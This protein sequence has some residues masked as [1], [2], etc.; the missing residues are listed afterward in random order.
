MINYCQYYFLLCRT[1]LTPLMKMDMNGQNGKGEISYELAKK[2][3]EKV[4]TAP[5]ESIVR[6]VMKLARK[7]VVQEA[8][9]GMRK[10]PAILACI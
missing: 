8:E 2:E 5:S 3:L 9:K 7:R 6:S 1:H 10:M 4:V